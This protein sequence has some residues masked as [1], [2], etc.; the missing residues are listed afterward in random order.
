MGIGTDRRA[1]DATRQEQPAALEALLAQIETFPDPQLRATAI[2]AIQALVQFYGDG[3]TRIMA[4]IAAHNPALPLVLVDDE[5]VA[6]LLLLHDLHPLDLE[7]R[8]NLALDEVRPYLRSHGGDVALLSVAG[9]VARLQLQGSCS[10]CPASSITLKLAVEDAIRKRA[11]DLERIEAENATPP[12]PPPASFVPLTRLRHR[13]AST[14]TGG[15]TWVTISDLVIREG[16]VT[17]SAVDG[18]SLLFL[19]LQGTLYAYRN[20][21]SA[22]GAALTGATLQGEALAC[23]VCAERY[24]ARRAGR[25]LDTPSRS[26]EPIPLLASARSV[27][28]AVPTAAR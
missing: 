28:V 4:T 8:V 21:C 18:V 20:A 26:L 5:L 11:P 14:G 7:Q 25:G 23:P 19:N 10:G 27:N 2:E 1:D 9:G 15:T 16:E 13:E 3:L 6:H 12:P 24:D 22:C 17:I